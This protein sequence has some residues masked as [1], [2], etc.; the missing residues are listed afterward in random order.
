MEI[1]N[2]LE[3]YIVQFNDIIPFEIL[4]NFL[5]FCKSLDYKKALIVGN[6]NPV[7]K[8]SIRKAG[9]YSLNDINAKSL[10]QI[11]WRNFLTYAFQSSINQYQKIYKISDPFKINEIQILKYE[12]TGHYKPHT[13]D[14]PSVHRRLSCIY[15]VNDNFTGGELEFSYLHSKK[16]NTIKPKKNKLIVWPSNFMYPHSVKPVTKGERYSVVSWAL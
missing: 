6:K 1:E 9:Q 8:E 2:D 4:P 14:S 5:K 11:H 16:I 12:N 3:K 13:D 15:F 7:V 10:T